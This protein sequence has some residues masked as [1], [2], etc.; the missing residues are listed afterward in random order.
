MK[1]STS[2]IPKFEIEKVAS[3]Y[4]CGCKRLFLARSINVRDSVERSSSDLALQLRI[5][6]VIKPSSIPTAIPIS[7][8]ACRLIA[9]PVNDT[10]MFGWRVSAIATAL[11]SKSVT[12]GCV[13]W[14]CL[15]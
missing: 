8:R 10:L 15:N 13:V 5:T 6:G 14:L 9:L 2:N 3:A 12:E 11:I 4:S 7:M 1:F